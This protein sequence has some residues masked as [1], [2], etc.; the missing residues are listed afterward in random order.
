MGSKRG[1]SVSEPVRELVWGVDHHPASVH[2]TLFL[3]RAAGAGV[4]G[5]VAVVTIIVIVC[6]FVLLFRMRP[7]RL[8][9]RVWRVVEL[10]AEGDDD[11]PETDEQKSL[12]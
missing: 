9:L 2:T 12:K 11:K 6:L 3:G 8:T 5:M 10:S 7:K 1:T 4:C